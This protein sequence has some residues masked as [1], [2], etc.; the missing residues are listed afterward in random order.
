[1][2]NIYLRSSKGTECVLRMLYFFL[3]LGQ[4]SLLLVQLCQY[5]HLI[6]F[7]PQEPIIPKN[8]DAFPYIVKPLWT[9][10]CL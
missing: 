9:E 7:I 10:V 4:C 6:F 8:D 2:Q 1:M 5:G 3:F